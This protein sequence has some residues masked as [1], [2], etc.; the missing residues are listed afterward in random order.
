MRDLAFE[1]SGVFG[2]RRNRHPAFTLVELLVVIGIISVL[3]SI[4]LPALQAAQ[5]AGTWVRYDGT[6]FTTGGLTEFLNRLGDWLPPP[7]GP[8][9]AE[10]PPS[11]VTRRAP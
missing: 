11:P 6:T 7:H 4:L 9:S 5:D 1:T 10:A 2:I 8:L 3:I